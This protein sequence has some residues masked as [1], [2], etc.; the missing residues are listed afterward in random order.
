MIALIGL[1]GSGKSTAGRHLSRRLGG[2]L[3]DSDAVIEHAIGMPIRAYFEAHGEAAFRDVEERVIDR[4]TA[5]ASHGV[6][7]TGGGVVLREANR[8]RLHQ[9]CTV[10]YL[11][12]VP[13]Q[14]IHR[15]RSDTKRPLLQVDDPL[16][17]LKALY[18][19]RDPL[20]R[21]TAHFTVDT[22]G[23][24]VS[25]LV[26]RVMAQLELSCSLP[27]TDAPPEGAPAP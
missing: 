13:A 3:V 27:P 26:N 21:R 2:A 11:R 9:R 18:A 1:P 17:R 5:E 19:E 23:S 14:L 15:L 7:A 4:L 16:K 12:A 24:S 10:I 20:Y 25:M 6:L 8:Q 22:R